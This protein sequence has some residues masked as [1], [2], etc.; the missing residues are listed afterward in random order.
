MLNKY[1][2]ML[3]K[4]WYYVDFRHYNNHYIPKTSGIYF[5]AS[6][7]SRI[8][9]VPVGLE[10]IYIGKSKNLR[11]RFRYYSN[12]R[13]LRD[14]RKVHN[15]GLGNFIRSEANL[16]FWYLET[17]INEIS[18]YETLLTKEFRKLNKKLTNKIIFKTSKGELYV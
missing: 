1:I 13:E 9:Q 7:K 5:F 17:E 8:L 10:V 15:K 16:E 2:N 3:N 11:K 18:I 4:H 12:Y 14:H 6:A